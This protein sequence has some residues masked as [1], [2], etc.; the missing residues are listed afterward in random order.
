MTVPRLSI[1]CVQSPDAEASPNAPKDAILNV[2]TGE[3]VSHFCHGSPP[4]LTGPHRVPI[5]GEPVHRIPKGTM[6]VFWACGV[7]PQKAAE[8]AKLDLMI[9]HAPGHG[10]ITDL[11]ADH[12]CLP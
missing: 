5:Y 11:K 6:P 8:A 2:G 1:H 12:V 7:T 4:E 3:K 9:T 10:F